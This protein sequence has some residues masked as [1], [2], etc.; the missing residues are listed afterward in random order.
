M[1]QNELC[2]KT[3]ECADQP[4]LPEATDLYCTAIYAA[5]DMCGE[6]TCR[7]GLGALHAINVHLE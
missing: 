4:S 6:T 2:G 1:E 7:R 5:A 3:K